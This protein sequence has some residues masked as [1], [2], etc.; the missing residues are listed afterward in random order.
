[1][2]VRNTGVNA[3]VT[4]TVLFTG[5]RLRPFLF[6]LKS[7][8]ITVCKS[9]YLS[10]LT[11]YVVNRIFC[12]QICLVWVSCS[13]FTIK[14]QSEDKPKILDFDGPLVL[15]PEKIFIESPGKPLVALNKLQDFSA[16]T[17]SVNPKIANVFYHMKF[18]EKRNLGMEELHKYSE[19]M[20]VNKPTIEY[21]EP[22]LQVKLWKKSET[23]LEPT[24]DDIIKFVSSK[25]KVSS[26]DYADKYGGSTKTA[27]MRL[28]ELVD[29]GI[30]EREGEKR[31]TKYF[32]KR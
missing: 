7:L 10:L 4:D 9:I 30:L 31:G 21:N 16:P 26:G 6:L 23:K 5:G 12:T 17:F 3:C 13:E 27:S 14:T 8:F 1:M 28:N 25:V 32:L 18:I 19:I 29:E 24:K 11:A 22:Y 15:M 20:G 2:L